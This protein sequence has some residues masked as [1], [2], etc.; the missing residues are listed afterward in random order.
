MSSL[1]SRRDLAA[2]LVQAREESQR[3]QLCSRELIGYAT[4]PDSTPPQSGIRDAPDGMYQT[5]I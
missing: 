4:A 5:P 3:S 2:A 1:P